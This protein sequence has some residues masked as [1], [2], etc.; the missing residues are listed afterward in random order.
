MAKRACSAFRQRELMIRGP[1]ILIHRPVVAWILV[2][3]SLAVVKGTR[4]GPGDQDRIVDPRL[5]NAARLEHFTGGKFLPPVISAAAKGRCGSWR[6]IE[7]HVASF[8]GSRRAAAVGIR[9]RPAVSLEKR[10]AA[11]SFIERA[12]VAFCRREDHFQCTVALHDP[13]VV[14]S[15]LYRFRKWPSLPT[16]LVGDHGALRRRNQ[17][18]HVLAR[19]IHGG[20]DVAAREGRTRRGAKSRVAC[21]RENGPGNNEE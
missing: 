5:S 4:K 20:R 16:D 8:N 19:Q 10:F 14:I 15:P 11:A 21:R 7:V 17:R 1:A 18:Q 9:R 13:R 2:V 3:C 12:T 6:D